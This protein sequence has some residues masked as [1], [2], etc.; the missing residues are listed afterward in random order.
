[1]GV[2]FRYKDG[3][4]FKKELLKR[5]YALVWTDKP[6]VWEKQV[7]KPLPV[8]EFINR[9]VKEEVEVLSLTFPPKEIRPLFAVVDQKIE[10]PLSLFEEKAVERGLL[11]Y[12]GVLWTKYGIRVI[13]PSLTL[14]D[15]KGAKVLKEYILEIEESLKDSSLRPKGIF[16][17]GIPGTGKSYSCF[18]SAGQMGRIVVEMNISRILEKERPVEAVE[19][20]FELLGT[21]PPSVVWIDEIDKVFREADPESERIKGRLLTLLEDFNTDRG[22]RGDCLFWITANDVRPIVQR[23]PEFFRRFDYLFFLQLPKIEEAEEISSYYFS[24][25]SLEADRELLTD[26]GTREKALIRVA[27]SFW[28][29]AFSRSS[30]HGERRFVY[31][32][33]E[34]KGLVIKLARRLRRKNTSTFTRKDLEEVMK[35]HYPAVIAYEEA[36]SAMKEQLKYFA[37]V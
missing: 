20:F 22:Y 28:E 35:K 6:F 1:L 26:Y 30:S 8:K 4:A 14:E 3:S 29:E 7:L 31:T 36:V 24:K 10:K 15:L 37:E 25:Y 19:E 23:N 17:I 5:K 16:L 33:A 9:A 21:L 12:E 18:C 27:S 2:W 13:K 11:T 34:I 32:P